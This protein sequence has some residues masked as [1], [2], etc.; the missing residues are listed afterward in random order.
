MRSF[1]ATVRWAGRHRAAAF[2]LAV[3]LLAVF[4]SVLAP[5]LT[6]YDPR[7][8]DGTVRLRPPG[9]ERHVLGTDALG[10]DLLSRLLYGGRTS[11]LVGTSVV[12]ISGIVG[13][14]LGLIAGYSPRAA[15]I[16]MRVMD[17]MMAFP[18]VI[19][20]IALVAA[21]GPRLSNIIIA[22][23]V[24]Y[25]PGMTRVVRSAVLMVRESEYVQAATAAGARDGW[26]IWRHI[27]PNCWG[28]IVVRATHVFSSAV[29]SE[30][31]LSF[32]GVGGDPDAASWGI[33]LSEAR[34][35]LRQA[36]WLA[37]LPGIWLVVTV[38]SLNLV[39]DGLRDMTDPRLRR[40]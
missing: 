13:T 19:L 9:S 22:L 25:A 27:L 38:L 40:R 8:I 32:L 34:N 15:A 31:S 10:R 21:L 24:V 5:G 14:F 11:L 30:S 18:G 6:P 2:G 35:H 12:A 26:V 33:M 1:T 23:S 3:L 39:G 28:P 20:A 36:P 16:V 7:T 37:A 17:G 4:T 29:L